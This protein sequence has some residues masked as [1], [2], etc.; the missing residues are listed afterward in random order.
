MDDRSSFIAEHEWQLRRR[1]HRWAMLPAADNF[2]RSGGAAS[3]PFSASEPQELHRGVAD[4]G[5]RKCVSESL[6]GYDTNRIWSVAA[7]LKT[8]RR[9]WQ[10]RGICGGQDAGGQE[11][12][13]GVLHDAG[14][15]ARDC[16]QR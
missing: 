13:D 12:A 7:I 10:G 9:V 2:R 6:V 5:R 4:D 1:R 3:Q 8:P 11:H 16:G 15:Q 14:R